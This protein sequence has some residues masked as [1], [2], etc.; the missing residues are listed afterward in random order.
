MIGKYLKAVMAV[1]PNESDRAENTMA[2]S[3]VAYFINGNTCLLDFFDLLFFY[4][5]SD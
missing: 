3:P 4:F 2:K 1:K 5:K